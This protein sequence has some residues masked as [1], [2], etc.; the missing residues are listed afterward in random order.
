MADNEE[1]DAEAMRLAKAMDRKANAAFEQK[2]REALQEAQ[3]KGK[4]STSFQLQEDGSAS[5]AAVKRHAAEISA[6][7]PLSTSN[8]TAS[9]TPSHG[10]PNETVPSG[11]LNRYMEASAR[12]DAEFKSRHEEAEREKQAQLAN[13][14]SSLSAYEERAR[15]QDIDLKRKHE[16]EERRRKDEIAATVVKAQ[17]YKDRQEAEEREFRRK[18]E[19]AARQKQETL[20][21]MRRADEARRNAALARDNEAKAQMSPKLS[22]PQPPTGCQNCG[23]PLTPSS[24]VN[25]KGRNFCYGCS[26]AAQADKCEGC[27]KPILSGTML[28]AANKK[29]H[30]DCLKCAKCNC[31]LNDGYRPRNNK[32]YCIPC[33]QKV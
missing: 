32:L 31:A 29:Y 1:V 20:D 27:G 13:F 23:N 9:H 21:A 33:S 12:S 22:S 14:G 16:E 15:Q 2:R 6:A 19:E 5:N 8:K 18:Q 24:T 10:I 7:T 11:E 4:V 25:V 26:V 30:A 3:R 28:K 17:S